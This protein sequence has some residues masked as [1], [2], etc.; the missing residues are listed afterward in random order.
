MIN[1][2]IFRQLR[3]IANDSCCYAEITKKTSPFTE[4]VRMT[5]QLSRFQMA[6]LLMK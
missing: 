1:H 2:V 3:P 4:K 5:N 6:E